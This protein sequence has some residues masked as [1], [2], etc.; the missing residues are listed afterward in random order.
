MV[1]GDASLLMPMVLKGPLNNPPP[2]ACDSNIG[3]GQ[4]NWNE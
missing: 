2:I 3:R 1:T 4:F